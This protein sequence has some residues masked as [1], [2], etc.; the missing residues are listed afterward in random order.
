MATTFAMACSPS[1]SFA[2]EVNQPALKDAPKT[3]SK[4]ITVRESE[5]GANLSLQVSSRRFKPAN[6]QGPIIQLV[7][8]VHIGDLAYYQE[9]QTHLKD[10]ELVLFE[11]VK[12]GAAAATLDN[13]DD[14]A[15]VKL[16]K[17]RQRL[18]AIMIERYRKQ[19]GA[20]PE[21][22]DELVGKLT[23]SQ[24]R[25]VTGAMLDAWGKPFNYTLSEGPNAGPA[26]FDLVSPG[27]GTPEAL[28]K[29]SDQP[30]L[31]KSERAS[32]SGQGIQ[33][34]LAE[35]LGLSFQ[36]SVMDY[37]QSSWR[38]SDMTIDQVQAKMAESGANAD[39]L[40][41]LLDGS[42]LSGRIAG[43]ILGIVKANPQLALMTKVMMVETLANAD[44][45]IESQAKNT[46]MSSFMKVI[47]HDRNEAVFADLEKVLLDEPHIKSV[48]I[49]YGAGHLPDMEERLITKFGY[50]FESQIWFPAISVDSKNDPATA[51]QIKSYRKMIRQMIEQNRGKPEPVAH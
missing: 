16:T 41:K 36:L 6:T 26:T 50:T 51:G 5:D 10:F 31:T 23:G 49:F 42:S 37:N 4:Y 2:Q 25:V 44:E 15:K 7:G 48:A 12:P 34:K 29:F 21:S 45:V 35:A 18:L 27:S 20:Y 47:V 9:L 28:V 19:H 43:F 22:V 38:N 30:P 3:E 32:R 13:A 39:A 40:F 46:G 11:G 17:S 14:A 33:T 1:M 24:A 8:V